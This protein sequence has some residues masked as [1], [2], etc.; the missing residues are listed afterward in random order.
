MIMRVGVNIT[1]VREVKANFCIYMIFL[2]EESLRG[3]I[4]KIEK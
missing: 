2:T 3:E 4:K 1:R